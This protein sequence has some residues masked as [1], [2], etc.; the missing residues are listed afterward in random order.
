MFQPTDPRDYS[1]LV[2]DC[3]RD[4]RERRDKHSKGQ[5]TIASCA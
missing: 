4:D 5:K 1:N 3:T 2:F